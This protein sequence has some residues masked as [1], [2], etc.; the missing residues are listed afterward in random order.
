MKK[1]HKWEKFILWNSKHTNKE[2]MYQCVDC[3]ITK[4]IKHKH[5][6][7]RTLT[8]KSKDMDGNEYKEIVYICSFCFK[9]KTEYPYGKKKIEEGFLVY[10]P[11]NLRKYG[12]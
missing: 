5:D 4:H 6:F 1:K 3:F 8:W 11:K 12:I 7:R 9:R 10:N 2:Y